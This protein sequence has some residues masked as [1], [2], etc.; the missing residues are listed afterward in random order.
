MEAKPAKAIRFSAVRGL[1]GSLLLPLARR[2]KL[3]WLAFIR[4]ARLVPEGRFHTS[5]LSWDAADTATGRG[6]TIP[7]AARQEVLQPVAQD[8]PPIFDI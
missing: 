5:N 3:V 6:G 2:P 4:E 1:S 8:V 7:R